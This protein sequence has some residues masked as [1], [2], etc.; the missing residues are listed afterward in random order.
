M[1]SAAFLALAASAASAGQ[2]ASTGTSSPIVELPASTAPTPVVPAGTQVR[3][4]VMDEVNSRSA[5][6]GDRFKLRVDEN[7]I[8]DGVIAIAVGAIAY[9]EVTNLDQS[10]AVGKPGSLGAKL[11]YIDLP[12]GRVPI[13]GEQSNRGDANTA[14]VVLG[15]LGFGLGGLLSRGNNAKLKA[16]AI[17]T[18]YV[19][20]SS[21]FK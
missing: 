20:G 7:V 18:G 10:G 3:L 14:G 1:V 8:V 4:M 19:A 6:V 17:F 5:N 2:T 11:L 9:G 21:T 16:G 15:V 13:T 12:S